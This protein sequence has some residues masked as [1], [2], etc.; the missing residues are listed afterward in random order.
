M[1][2]A[3]AAVTEVGG[4]ARMQRTGRFPL[5]AQVLGGDSGSWELLAC[6]SNAG[7]ADD[8]SLAGEL[9]QK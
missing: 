2:A 5:A 9:Q 8:V 4:T 6:E 3:A 7:R 1:E